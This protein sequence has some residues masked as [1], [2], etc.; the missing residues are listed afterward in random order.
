LMSVMR[1]F[2]AIADEQPCTQGDQDEDD[3]HE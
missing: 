1:P 3:G 2:E